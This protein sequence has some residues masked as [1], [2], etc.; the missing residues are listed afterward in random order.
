MAGASSVNGMVFALTA[1]PCGYMARVARRTA[2]HT[3]LLKTTVSTGSFSAIATIWQ[4]TG[5]AKMCEPSPMQ[6]ITWRPRSASW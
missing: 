1:S 5:L 4:A 6:A 2:C 3:P